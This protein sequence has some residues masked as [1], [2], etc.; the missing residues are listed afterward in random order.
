MLRCNISASDEKRKRAVEDSIVNFYSIGPVTPQLLVE[1][2]FFTP[3][4]PVDQRM[5]AGGMVVVDGV[6]EFGTL[7]SLYI[8]TVLKTE[9]RTVSLLLSRLSTCE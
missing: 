2:F 8:H 4:Q 7:V 9:L 6:A 5:E 1:E 3:D